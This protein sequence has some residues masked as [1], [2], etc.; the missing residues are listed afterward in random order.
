MVVEITKTKT[1]RAKEP[2]PAAERWLKEYEDLGWTVAK[3][4]AD[5]MRSGLKVTVVLTR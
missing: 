5:H 1:F 4:D 2:E 3:Y